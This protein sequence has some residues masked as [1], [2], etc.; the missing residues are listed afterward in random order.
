MTMTLPAMMVWG[1][2][3]GSSPDATTPGNTPTPTERISMRAVDF[4]PPRDASVDETTLETLRQAVADAPR[5]RG[6]RLSLV[7]ALVDGG[8][9]EDALTE[10]KAWREVDAYNLVVVR[11]IGDILTE[12]RRPTDALRTYSAVTELLPEDPQAQRALATVLE[13]QGDLPAAHARLTVAHA[14]RPDDARL[15]FE[16]ADVALRLDEEA[17][18]LRLLQSIAD[19]GE[20][21]EALRYPAR[22]RLSQIYSRQRRAARTAGNEAVVAQLD[23]RI[24][25]LKLDGGSVNDIKIYLSWDTDRTDVDLWVIT[26]SGKTINY[27]NKR[28]RHGGALFRDVT[29]GY[30]PESFTMRRAREGTYQVKV[31][32]FSG[33]NGDFKEA[34]GE[35]IVV[36]DEGRDTEVQQSFPYRLYRPKQTVT[37]AEIEVEARR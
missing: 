22:Q 1:V 32:Y 36:L 37:V 11:L 12:Q 21:P 28:G 19:D 26:P 10:A 2:L 24:D 6:A 23:E 16:L 5:D 25:A 34:R 9:L 31:N 3:T 20:T 7:R 17:E 33:T 8:Q 30:G 35:V 29:N 13:Q 27:E 15:K 4:A 14:L 18:S